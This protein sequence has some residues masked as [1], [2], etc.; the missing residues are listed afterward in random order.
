[1]RHLVRLERRRDIF[2]TTDLDRENLNAIIDE[3]SVRGTWTW[4]VT[5]SGYR[6]S[7]ESRGREQVLDQTR[8]FGRAFRPIRIKDRIEVDVNADA[9]QI[10]SEN[11]T[12]R[13]ALT[14]LYRWQALPRRLQIAPFVRFVK[15][16]FQDG[17]L[18][19]PRLGTS[20]IWSHFR[21]SFSSVFGFSF[22]Y[23]QIDRSGALSGGDESSTSFTITETLTHGD[24]TRLHKELELSLSR[25]EL[26]LSQELPTDP[27]DPPDLRFVNSVGLQDSA[28][29]R[30]K[31]SRRRG[32]RSWSGWI[33]LTRGESTG[34][35]QPVP[36]TSE[37]LSGNLQLG[38]GRFNLVANLGSSWLN[39]EDDEDQSIQFGRLWVSWQLWTHLRLNAF[40]RLNR[41]SL[42]F[43]PDLDGESLEARIDL[44]IGQVILEARVFETTQEI[45]ADLPR[46]NRG[47]NWSIRRRF[48]SWLPIVSAPK[49][50]GTIR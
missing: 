16:D 14:T 6:S 3:R 35:L 21:P 39:R 24:P 2:G 43:A 23:G 15:Q 46:T 19:S 32:T 1:M 45:A 34:D 26:N 33:D 25:S 30:A 27:D 41:Q 18:S 40:Y 10:D 49:R 44:S 12:R 7:F 37:G 50:R 48:A 47:F 36:F 38:L 13:W 17:E 4:M 42:R 29:L 20:L 5:G 11:R 28:R 22:N 31:L 8:L 9:S